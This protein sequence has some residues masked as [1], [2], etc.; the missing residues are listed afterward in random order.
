MILMFVAGITM[1]GL[2]LSIAARVTEQYDETKQATDDYLSCQNAVYI[3][4]DTID[5]LRERTMNYIVTGNLKE[6]TAYFDEIL[7]ARAMDKAVEVLKS[8][9]TEERSLQQLNTAINLH[10]MMAKMQRRAMR[11]AMQARGQDISKY[12]LLSE[13]KLSAEELSLSPDEQL[14]QALDMLYTLDYTHLKGQVDVRIRLCKEGLTVSMTNRQQSVSRELEQLLQRQRT[15]ITIMS[16]GFLL[17]LVFVM[18]LVVAPIN[19][20]IKLIQKKAEVAVRGSSEI[21]FLAETY[22]HMRGQMEAANSR[23]SYEAAHDALTGVY[24]RS[25]FEEMQAGCAGKNIALL[26]LDVD[27]FKQVN[28]TYGHDMGDRVLKRVAHV[29]RASFREA[30]MVCRIGGDEFCVFVVGVTSAAENVIGEK[31]VKL[32]DTLREPEADVPGVTVSVGCA[33]SDRLSGEESIIKKADRALYRVK[34]NG[35]DSFCFYTGEDM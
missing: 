18:T 12:P 34:K 9:L 29:L 5:E 21:I 11:L 28:D 8:Y 24:N 20:L 33:F 13:V 14:A 1:S 16:A 15:L 3:V 4:R 10:N 6:V 19:R 35:R 27:F 30:D 32:A 23:L 25:A 7:T 26:I 2:L 22:N 31:L 17:V